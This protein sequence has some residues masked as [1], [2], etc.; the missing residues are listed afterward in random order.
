MVHACRVDPSLQQ[1]LPVSSLRFHSW[2][3]SVHKK[4]FF[5]TGV[6]YHFVVGDARKTCAA[7]SV[8]ETTFCASRVSP[9][10]CTLSPSIVASPSSSFAI[11]AV[12]SH[13]LFV[14]PPCSNKYLKYKARNYERFLRT[15][16][17]HHRT[18]LRTIRAVFVVAPIDE[19]TNDSSGPC[20][21]HCVCVRVHLR[22]PEQNTSWCL[23]RGHLCLICLEVNH[24]IYH[25]QNA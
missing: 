8:D 5:P 20:H 23:H 17:D 18:G 21:E 25:T 14:V 1:I 9:F 4:I 19:S 3:H 11:I 7:M 2:P 6:A 22:C 12:F 24:T 16:C 15:K 10:C 13:K